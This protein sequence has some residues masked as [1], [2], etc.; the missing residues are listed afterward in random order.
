MT[1]KKYSL[2]AVSGG[3]DSMA[4]L[5]MLRKEGKDLIVCHVNYGVRESALRDENIVKNYCS[6]HGIKIEVLKGFSYD[7]TEGNFE[8]WARVIRYNFFKEMYDKYSCESLYVGHNLDDLLET[9]YIQKE[10][11]SRCDYYGLKDEIFIYDMNVKRILLGYSK[12]E[13]RIY[14]VDNNIDYGVDE[15]NFDENYLR[16][17]IRHNVIKNM[18]SD[19]KKK[20]L[21]EINDLNKAK[22]A[23]YNYF[24]VL[25]E[26][27]RV[28]N[29][30]IDLSIFNE[31]KKEDKV[32]ILYYFVIENVKKRISISEAR[33]E[34]IISKINSNKP[35]IILGEFE[36]FILYKE[37]SKLTIKREVND[38]CY[39]INDLN[40]DLGEYIISDSGKK[41]EKVVVDKSLF[42]LSIENYKGNDKII[43]RLFIDKKVPI[44]ERK[45]W[46][47]IKDKLGRVLLVLNIKKFYN[48]IDSSPEK[49][50]E[51]YVRK[52]E[53]EKC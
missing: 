38:Y 14:C 42:P 23:E 43:N 18:S 19:D 39:V 9:Y 1:D 33:V 5:D 45:N 20:V 40:S 7:K 22:N 32:S 24:H 47:I 53:E 2:V 34:D 21:N 35:N 46:P 16:N 4:L 25:L 37:Y 6:K 15:T 48:I 3:S 30:S 8:N 11:N 29:N 31:N 12:E 27:C 49:T 36:G 10:R 13:L 44:S 28:G 51:F 17:N 41:L 50:I 52:K 26:K